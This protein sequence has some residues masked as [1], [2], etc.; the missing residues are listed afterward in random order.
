MNLRDKSHNDFIQRWAI[1][2][3]ESPRDEWKKELGNFLNSQINQ[4]NAFYQR[5]SKT[6]NGVEKIKKL[7]N[8]SNN[9]LIH[10]RYFK[11]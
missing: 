11:K 9:T 5:L 3:R 4:S 2:V 1:H 6:Q 7:R 8:I 10:R